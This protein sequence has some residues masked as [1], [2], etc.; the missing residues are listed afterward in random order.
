M[1]MGNSLN[2]KSLFALSKNVPH[3]WFR[4]GRSFRCSDC[5]MQI[6]LQSK[7]QGLGLSL[8]TLAPRSWSWSWFLAT[9]LHPTPSPCSSRLIPHWR[10]YWC[11]VYRSQSRSWCSTVE[12]WTRTATVR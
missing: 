4:T 10:W 7:F 11:C 6:L 3:Y 1:D 9:T 5:F 8:D 2:I 12:S